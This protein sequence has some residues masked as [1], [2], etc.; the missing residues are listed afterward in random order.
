MLFLVCVLR[1]DAITVMRDAVLIHP[2]IED[3][4]AVARLG[5]SGCREPRG[6]EQTQDPDYILQGTI[7]E[8]KAA[9]IVR[10]P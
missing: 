6:H 1:R 2:L 5:R 9:A 10:E 3:A 8:M 7:L 4:A